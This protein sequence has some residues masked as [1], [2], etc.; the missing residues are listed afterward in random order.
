MPPLPAQ[1]W[2][3]YWAFSKHPLSRSKYPGERKAKGQRP[4]TD[5]KQD[6]TTEEMYNKIGKAPVAQN[7]PFTPRVSYSPRVFEYLRF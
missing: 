5:H 2:D 3:S 4:Y 1:S 6:G 7:L